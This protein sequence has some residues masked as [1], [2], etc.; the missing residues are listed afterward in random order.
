MMRNFR[1]APAFF[2][3]IALTGLGWGGASA[4][5]ETG[6][7]LGLNQAVDIALKEHP[8]I[9]QTRETAAAARYNIGVAGPPI[10]PRSIL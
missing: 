9:K 3:L 5:A 7:S 6:G 1:R 2:L 8:A 10:Y 4:A